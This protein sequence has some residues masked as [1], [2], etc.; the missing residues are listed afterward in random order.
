[1]GLC[2]G[3]QRNGRGLRKVSRARRGIGG[4]S[5][6]ASKRRWLATAGES[7]LASLEWQ[8]AELRR[9]LETAARFADE[10]AAIIAELAAMA[11]YRPTRQGGRID[12]DAP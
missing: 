6:P 2:Q 11:R 10:R 8:L 5:K 12:R 9:E 1:M 4:A 3:A 7:A